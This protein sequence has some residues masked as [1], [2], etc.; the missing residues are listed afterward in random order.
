MLVFDCTTA[1][2]LSCIRPVRFRVTSGTRSTTFRFLQPGTYH[3]LIHN[4][5]GVVIHE[6]LMDITA[7]PVLTAQPTQSVLDASDVPELF[8]SAMNVHTLEPQPWTIT[9]LQ[10]MGVNENGEAFV[11]NA[12]DTLEGFGPDVVAFNDLPPF[13]PEALSVTAMIESNGHAQGYTWNWNVGFLR[14]VT[15]LKVS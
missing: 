11:E 1:R 15:V 7:T 4:H 3:W 13:W 10:F 2:G 6:Q 14:P 9:N 5:D 12:S 8:I